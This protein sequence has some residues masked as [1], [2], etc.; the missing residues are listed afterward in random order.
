MDKNAVCVVIVISIAT[1]MR[2]PVNDQDSLPGTDRETFRQNAAGK[3]G[4]DNEV[5]ER[6]DSA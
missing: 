1:N 3:T 5:V 6:L 2:T 4:S